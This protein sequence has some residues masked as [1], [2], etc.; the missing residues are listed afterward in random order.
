[1]GI[2]AVRVVST[3]MEGIM[4]EAKVTIEQKPNDKWACFLHLPE[5]AEP[6]DLG[7]EFK[8]EE[9]AEGWLDTS[10]AVTAIDLFTRKHKK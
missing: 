2:P 6:V 9:R 1:M 4:A 3:P 8:S 5:V 7:M 10:E